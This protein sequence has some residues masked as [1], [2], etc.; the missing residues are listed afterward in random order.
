MSGVSTC[1]R[2]YGKCYM[3]TH[4]AD[5][6]L[7]EQLTKERDEARAEVIENMSDWGGVIVGEARAADGPNLYEVIEQLT[8]ERDE[9]R[10]EV[11]ALKARQHKECAQ[12]RWPKCYEDDAICVDCRRE[13]AHQERLKEEI[14][15][16]KRAEKMSAAWKMAAKK[17][18][19][20]AWERGERLDEFCIDY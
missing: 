3:D 9:A 15:R 14:L 5:C 4:C 20:E 1:K 2:C 7:I 18:A 10:A 17:W 12:C 11:E 19:H 6:R 16:R 8:K 13:S